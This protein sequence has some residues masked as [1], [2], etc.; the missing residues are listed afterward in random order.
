MS[1]TIE[2]VQSLEDLDTIVDTDAHVVESV[3]DFAPYIDDKY[4]GLR[5]I[6][7]DTR[8]PLND[9]YTSTHS[10][11]PGI[12]GPGLYN[13]TNDPDSKMEEMAEFGI[14]YGIIN[15]TLNLAINTVENSRLAVALMNGYNNW[16]LAELLDEHDELKGTI[17]IA[18][19]KPDL[20]A[21]EI[22]RLADESDLVGVQMPDTGLIPPA[23]HEW[24]NPIYEAAED[25]DLPMLF[26]SGNNSTTHAW[27][28]QRMWNETYIENHTIVHPFSHMWNITTMIVQGV[29]AR[30]PDLDFVFQEAGIGY[31][32]YLKWR[33]DD[34]YLE[35]SDEA[36]YLDQLPS[37]YMADQF[38]FTTQP[39]GHTAENP[40]HLA[41]AVEMAGPDNVMYSSDLPHKD[42]D[43]PGELFDRIH[44]H[45]DAETVRN[46]MGETAID[47]FD[48]KI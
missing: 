19:Q 23:G 16:A 30:Y 7:L 9:I 42:F 43:P 38:Y 8:N 24:Y 15:P 14:D 33:L 10:L 46:I 17:L 32:S 20:A 12:G 47:I 3:E 27:M 44:T 4:T 1:Q 5:E 28:Q 29:P 45:F 18:P 13:W 31:I 37:E 6:I 11:P 39:L 40:K 36:P 2:R 26:H 34:H 35:R 41:W 22:D 48:L 25:N 21:E